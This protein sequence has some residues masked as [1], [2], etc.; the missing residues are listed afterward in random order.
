MHC[1]RQ[2]VFDQLRDNIMALYPGTK[3]ICDVPYSSI[4]E[5]R[6][7][8]ELILPNPAKVIGRTPNTNTG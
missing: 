7:Q 6:R 8:F 5:L 1:V 2:S 3:R 4:S